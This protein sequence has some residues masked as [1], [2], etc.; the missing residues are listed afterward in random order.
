MN[1]KNKTAHKGD[2]FFILTLCAVLFSG[3][4]YAS[5]EDV[6]SKP[7]YISASILEVILKHPDTNDEIVIKRNQDRQATIERAYSRVARGKINPMYPFKPYNV[8]TIGELE[9]I[10][11]LKKISAGNTDIVIIDTRKRSWYSINGHIPLS[12]NIPAKKFRNEYSSMEYMEEIFG[13]L[14]GGR[15][16]D[17]TYAKTLVLYCNGIWC[18]KTPSVIKKLL[19]Y[20]YPSEKLKY[21]RGGMQS[22]KSLGLPVI[23]NYVK[24]SDAFSDY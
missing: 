4:I 3:K 1:L 17:F 11:Y 12:I 24:P 10:D 7:V 14:I 20:G 21:Y 22:W 19:S 13:I 15:L 16:L 6:A 2:I 18:G 23:K 5:P 8:E 9:V